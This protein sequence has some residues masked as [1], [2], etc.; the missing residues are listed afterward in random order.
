MQAFVLVRKGVFRDGNHVL[1]TAIHP[2]FS[3]VFRYANFPFLSEIKWFHV[4]FDFPCRY[5][6]VR[7]AYIDLTFDLNSIYK[8]AICIPLRKVCL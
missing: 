1:D 7:F 6:S 2:F 4:T 3:E 5:K 8:V